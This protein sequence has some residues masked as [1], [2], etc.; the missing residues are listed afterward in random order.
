MAAIVDLHVIER[1]SARL[2]H[3]LISPVAAIANGIELLSEEEPEFARE[4]AALV[5]ESVRKASARLQF[6]RFAFGFGGGAMAGAPPHQLAAEFFGESRIG[7]DYSETARALSLEWQKL[8]CNLLLVAAEAL[9]RGGEALLTAT[10]GGVE[11]QAS[12]EGS[13]ASAEIREA[14][15]L[16]TATADLTSRTVI[17]YLAGLIAQSLGCRIAVEDAPGNFRLRAAPTG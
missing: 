4:A 12:G 15:S 11:V 7:C 10:A 2:C 14:L 9:P 16:A 3:E 17:A 5:G 6:F 1:L 8:G 13:G